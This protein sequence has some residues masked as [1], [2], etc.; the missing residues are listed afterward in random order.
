MTNKEMSDIE[1]IRK[2]VV[3]EWGLLPYHQP[4]NLEES[5]NWRYPLK[6]PENAH[7]RMLGY[8]LNRCD[9]FKSFDFSIKTMKAR[10]V[11]LCSY[12]ELQQI[13]DFKHCSLVQETFSGRLFHG[14]VG[15]GFEKWSVI[16]KTCDVLLPYRDAHFQ[17]LPKFCD[18]I[19][20][21][22]DEK[23]MHIKLAKLCTLRDKRL[24]VV[25]DEKIIIRLS[26]VLLNGI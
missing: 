6:V 14:T 16:V 15:E 24:V 23:Q 9:Q 5:P 21:F 11:K 7:R 4:F 19:K 18:E 25:Y 1:M 22:I 17:R 10:G 13:T 12:S 8:F 2:K 3:D 20:L 26:D